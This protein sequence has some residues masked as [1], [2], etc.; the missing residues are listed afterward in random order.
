MGH[1]VKTHPSQIDVHIEQGGH[2]LGY[3]PNAAHFDHHALFLEN[4]LLLGVNDREDGGRHG[5]IPENELAVYRG[6]VSVGT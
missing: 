6:A 3:A 1:P 2:D 5:R 4:T